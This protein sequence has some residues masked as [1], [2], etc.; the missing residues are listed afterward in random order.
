MVTDS[1][2]YVDLVKALAA[3]QA[4]MPVVKKAKR[5]DTG[6]FKYTY[7][8][9][10]DLTKKIMPLLTKHGLVFTASPER[11]DGVWQLTGTLMHVG[12]AAVSG[13]LPIDASGLSI[14]L[15]SSLTYARRYLLGCLTGVVTDDDVDAPPVT[16]ASRPAP[17][18][19]NLAPMWGALKA[20]GVTGRDDSLRF[21]GKVLGREV[22]SSASLTA[23]DV[24]AVIEEAHTL[25]GGDTDAHDD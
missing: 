9:L 15:G 25:A 17:P 13:S 12:G 7:A 8:D 19:V 3:F 23:E 24:A 5:A 6:K 20:A 21:V 11:V 10:A 22:S 16:R 2:A 18:S 14:A 4:E 1:T